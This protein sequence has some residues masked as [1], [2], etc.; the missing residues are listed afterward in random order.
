M[1]TVSFLGLGKMGFAMAGCLLE[2]GHRLQVYNRT[3]TKAEPLVHQGAHLAATAR[4]ACEG[5]NA[6]ISMTADDSSSRAMW[7]GSDG[8]LSADLAPGTFAIECSTLSHGW[9]RELAAAATGRQLRFIDAPV[10]G[11]PEDAERGR[12]TLLVGAVP[13]ELDAAKPLLAGFSARVIRLGP[14][15]SGTVYKL[16]INLMGAVQIASAAEGIA[17]AERAGLDL[18]TVVDAI[19]TS[20]ASS[21]QVV[22]NTRR[23]L[24]DDHDRNVVFTPALRLKDVEYAL[25][26]ARELRIGSPFGLVARNALQQLCERGPAQVNES[27]IIEVARSQPHRES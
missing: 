14:P 12:L 24:A 6:V 3:A 22:R 5:A 9:V 17:I 15:G 19:A 20:Q 4:E 18:A 11:L 26:L 23:M 27:K 2:A 21:P 7:F 1:A 16:V 13:E 10:T 8:A 25:S